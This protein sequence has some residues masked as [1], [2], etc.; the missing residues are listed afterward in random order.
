MTTFDLGAFVAE[1]TSDVLDSCRKVDLLEIARHYEIPVS[2]TL[3]VGELREAVLAGLV[4]SEVLVLPKSSN[5]EQGVTAGGAVAS[6]VR[7]GE[8]A[9]SPQPP[10]GS[11]EVL[12]G[13]AEEKVRVLS[14]TLSVH[15]PRDVRL[16]VRL[17]R[18]KNER[19]EKERD[20]QLKRE[21]ELKRIELEAATIREVEF[22]S[23]VFPVAVRDQF[24]IDRVEFIM[25]NDIAGGEVYPSPEVVSRPILSTGKDELAEE[26][27]EMFSV[28][29]LTR[30]QSKKLA[31]E[32]GDVDLCDSVLAPVF[33]GVRAP[34]C[35]RPDDHARTKASSGKSTT[36]MSPPLTSDALIGAQKFGRRSMLLVS[37]VLSTVMSA[38]SAF[39]TSYVMFAVTRA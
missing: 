14:P 18:L 39:S 22:R 15:S 26:H 16:D 20:F 34:P 33:S 38:A 7:L 8:S 35:G 17:A 12:F 24:P 25:G 3:R 19:E 11:P 4:A 27:P 28:C 10:V 32:Q 29:V 31:E 23:G 21:L 36:A 9:D 6:P 13:E 1:P 30:A 37:L 5:L 2:V